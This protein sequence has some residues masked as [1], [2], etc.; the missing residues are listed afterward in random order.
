MPKTSKGSPLER[1]DAHFAS[2]LREFM[3][4]NPNTGK[5]TTQQ[6]LAKYLGVRPQ[7]V[8]LYCTGESLPNCDTLLK[9]AEYYGVSCD[10]L[11]IGKRPENIPVREMLGL[12]E[13]TVQNMK[14][15]KDGYFE[16]TPEMLAML[17]S[18]LG[19]KD[20]YLSIE[21]AVRWYK[22]KETAPDDSAQ[23]FCEWKATRYMQDY[24]LEALRRNL[25]AIYNEQQE[26][27]K[28]QQ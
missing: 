18:L 3:D 13:N 21:N 28:E 15:V 17:D 27:D 5:R 6:D 1:Y 23:E 8:S 9:I 2:T 7:T 19:D 11:M 25:T 26:R 20:F 16:D 14:L 4:C 10:F 24:L 12:S 22:A